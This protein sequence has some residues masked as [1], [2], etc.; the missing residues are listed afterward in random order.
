MYISP[1]DHIFV[2]LTTAFFSPLFLFQLLP[3]NIISCMI[4]S[5]KVITLSFEAFPGISLRCSLRY[6]NFLNAMRT[7]C[8]SN[9][10]F[11]GLK[12]FN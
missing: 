6:L 12:Y 5:H 4:F 10:F 9:A 1:A 2:K 8:A 3:T 11:L 7:S